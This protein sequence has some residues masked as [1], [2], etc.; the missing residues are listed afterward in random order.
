MSLECH[1]WAEMGET[2][3]VDCGGSV[4]EVAGVWNWSVLWWFQGLCIL[5]GAVAGG[6]NAVRGG[7]S[8][9]GGGS[10]ASK[11]ECVRADNCKAHPCADEACHVRVGAAP[12]LCE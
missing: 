10:V 11:K 9:E 5:E 6:C 2:G 7:S 12:F 4:W 3:H 1:W 8:A